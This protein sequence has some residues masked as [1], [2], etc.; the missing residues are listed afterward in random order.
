MARRTKKPPIIPPALHDSFV[1]ITDPRSQKSQLH[2]FATVLTIAVCATISGADSWVAIEGWAKAK[3]EWLSTFLDLKNGVP[4]HDTFGRL[5]A[6]MDPEEFQRAFISWTESIAES[7]DGC[8]VAIDG[9]TLRR[10]FDRA[11][12]RSAIHMVNA[13]V[14]SQG[15]S[16]GQIKTEEKSNEITAVPALIRLLK[17][18]G[19]IVT[20][21][22]MGCQKKITQAICEQEADYIIAV[23]NNQ[24]TLHQEITSWFSRFPEFSSVDETVMTASTTERSRN[25]TEIRCIWLSP[26]PSD[27][28]L[29]S[30]WA[31]LQSIA[32]VESARDIDG[33]TSVFSRY[34]ISSLPAKEPQKVLQNIREHW[35]VENSLHWVLDMSFRED[36]SRIRIDNAAENMARL[37]QIAINLV[38]NEPTRKVG[39]Q[40]SRM[41]AGWDHDY[42]LTILKQNPKK[43]ASKS[44]ALKK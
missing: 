16:L 5:F 43:L 12:G 33:K 30:E 38:K 39:V 6:A 9:K 32:R 42:L 26:I 41:R 44:G 35:G 7:L 20:L 13:W 21:D 17:L 28:P 40:T 22:A 1:R 15:L 31:G 23:K 10:S 27:F 18:K 19:A 29:T 34:Y 3:A 2:S 37:R 11:N 25:R 24:R 36:E 8:V 14:T 4:S